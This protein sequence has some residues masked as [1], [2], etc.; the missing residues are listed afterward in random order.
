M[1]GF[2]LC[3]QTSYTRPIFSRGVN[4][5][6]R[7]FKH[8]REQSKYKNRREDWFVNQKRRVRRT[9]AISQ[10]WK[11]TQD[12]NGGG[13]FTSDQ[14]IPGSPDWEKAFGPLSADSPTTHWADIYFMS[15]RPIRDGV[16]YNTTIVTIAD[17]FKE[18]L[19]EEAWEYA[20]SLLSKDQQNDAWNFERGFNAKHPTFEEFG[21]R[22]HYGAQSQYMQKVLANIEQRSVYVSCTLN[23]EFC[24]GVGLDMVSDSPSLTMHSII[25]DIE[26]FRQLGEQDFKLATDITPHL[27]AIRALLRSSIESFERLDARS[28]SLPEPQFTWDKDEA[29]LVGGFGVPLKI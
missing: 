13:V 14:Y 10:R 23:K 3:H 6:R 12:R 5:G 4:M 19:E 27:P 21:G 11:I 7:Q 2:L 26:R 9:K 17:H 28:R 22:T 20:D 8:V 25:Q 15:N 1:K 24:Y 29:K 18:E 16:F